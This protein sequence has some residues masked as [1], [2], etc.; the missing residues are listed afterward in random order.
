[1]GDYLINDSLANRTFG[2]PVDWPPREDDS[3]DPTPYSPGII[4][5]FRPNRSIGFNELYYFTI[6][7]T[8]II[9]FMKNGVVQDGVD[10]IKADE[11]TVVTQKFS[12]TEIDDSGN[13]LTYASTKVVVTG[14]NSGMSAILTVTVNTTP[15]SANDVSEREKEILRF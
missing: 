3:S 7:N 1:M 15:G 2:L 6:Q 11:A 4:E 5:T 14:I 8:N 9:K 13:F 10:R 12:T